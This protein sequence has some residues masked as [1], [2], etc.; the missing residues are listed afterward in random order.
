[1]YN[2][3][4]IWHFVIADPV[5]TSATSC[6]EIRQKKSGPLVLGSHPDFPNDFK[7][8]L[9]KTRPYLVKKCGWE[10]HKS[11]DF[12]LCHFD[13]VD[14]GLSKNEKFYGISINYVDR[15]LN[16]F[17]NFSHLVDKFTT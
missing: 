14:Y 9:T 10:N 15:I 16:I 6:D 5:V 11:E 3:I 2:T 4:Y 13:F 17:D 7:T 12:M 1:M 8:L